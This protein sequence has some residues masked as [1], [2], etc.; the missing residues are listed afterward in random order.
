MKDFEWTDT[1]WAVVKT[2]GKFAGCPCLTHE[3][4]FDLSAQHEGSHIFCMDSKFVDQVWED[5]K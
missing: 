1:L 4:A 3:E 5:E 2:D